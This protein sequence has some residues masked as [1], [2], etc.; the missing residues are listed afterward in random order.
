[1]SEPDAWTAARS[2]SRP[3]PRFLHAR[4]VVAQRL[5]HRVDDLRRVEARGVILRLRG[6]LV[7]ERVGQPHR[8][9]LQP[10]VDQPLVARQRQRS[11]EHTSELQSLMRIS[12]A[13]FFLTKNR[14]S[15]NNVL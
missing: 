11:E 13:V 14:T 9:Q 4:A 15:N 5:Q 1:M 6:V 7:L 10:R 3:H 12:Y 2:A 8:P